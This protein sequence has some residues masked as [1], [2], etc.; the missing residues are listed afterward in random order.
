MNSKTNK[1]EQKYT[2]YI[3]KVREKRND[4]YYKT[5][6]LKLTHAFI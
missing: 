6:K 4:A 1:K 2:Q 3:G 5:K